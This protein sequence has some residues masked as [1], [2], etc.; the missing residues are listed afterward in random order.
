MGDGTTTNRSMSV[1]VLGLGISGK[2]KAVSKGTGFSLGL[3]TDGICFTCGDNTYG[4]LGDNTTTSKSTPVSVI[5]P[6]KFS[7]ISSGSYHALALDDYGT[8]WVW[9]R[10][11]VGQLGLGSTVDYSSPVAINRGAM[12]FV[13]ISAV[14]N[15]SSAVDLDGNVWTWGT[16]ALGGSASNPVSI[17]NFKARLKKIY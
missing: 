1:A 2:T 5:A 9:G 4:S 8:L 11:N 12:K 15:S 16:L 17:K 13:Q 7:Q 10:N 6:T 14:N 3:N